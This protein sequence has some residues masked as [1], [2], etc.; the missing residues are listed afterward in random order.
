MRNGV[1]GA[2]KAGNN[3][4]SDQTIKMMAGAH[5]AGPH[6]QNLLLQPLPHQSLQ[7]SQSL[8]LKFIQSN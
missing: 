3:R 6:Q 2:V 8:K 7:L 5:G 4:I 1:G